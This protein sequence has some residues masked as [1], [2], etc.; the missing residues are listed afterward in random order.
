MNL[1]DQIADLLDKHVHTLTIGHVPN[2]PAKLFVMA[3]VGLPTGEAG[4]IVNARCQR[5]GTNLPDLLNSI[6][7]D[8]FHLDALHQAPSNNKI[9][10][11]RRPAP[12]S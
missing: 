1:T 6:R 10:S 9:I 4:D 7:G 11:V 5:A 8:V 2:D 3:E 12:T